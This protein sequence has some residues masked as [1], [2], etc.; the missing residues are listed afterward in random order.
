[1]GWMGAV[2]MLIT[3]RTLTT[4]YEKGTEF[5]QIFLS[6]MV[7]IM[8]GP[9]LYNLMGRKPIGNTLRNDGPKKVHLAL[10]SR[11]LL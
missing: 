7:L 4:P 6:S 10:K 8:Q 2:K 11:N 5:F 3:I 9:F 1:M